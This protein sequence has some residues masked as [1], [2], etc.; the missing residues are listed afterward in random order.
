VSDGGER[1]GARRPRAGRIPAIAALLAGSVLLSRVLGQV[2]EMVLA[3]YLGT[4][5]E[6][7]AYRAAFQIPDILNHFL[8]GGA[9]SV[10]FVPFYTHVRETRGEAAALRLL[11]TVLGTLTAI[12]VVATAALWLG[13]E[14]LVGWLFR[15]F[16]DEPR[17]LTLRLTRILLPAQIFFVAGGVLRAALM[18]NDRFATQALAPLVYNAG[19]IAGG[20]LFGATLGAEG[21]AWGALAGAVVGPF[22]LPLLDIRRAGLG[23]GFRIAPWE[24]DFL[25]YLWRAA[26]LILGLSLLTVD[27]WYDKYFGQF[28]GEGVVAQL[29]YARIVMLAPVAVVGQAV[30]TAA[31]PAFSQL[32][33]EG[34]LPELDR[35]VLA[36][37]RAS[38]G[39]AVLMGAA[40]WALAEPVT[41]LL[42]ERGA[43][44]PED[45][46]RVSALLAVFA[47]AVPA[48]VTQQ[49]AGRAFFAREDM[50]RPMLLGTAVA[51]LAIPLYRALGARFGGEGL[52][53]AGVLAMSANA[54]LLL[55]M[56]RLVH[57][58]PP[59]LPL[60]ATFAR[61]LVVG[62][63]A[64]A[65]AAWAAGLAGPAPAAFALGVAAFGVV[66][67]PGIWWLGDESVREVLTR[68]LSRLRRRRG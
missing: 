8:A 50:W 25:A 59:L 27:E 43:F 5:P 38:L 9:F 55:V 34:R 18:A 26:P 30:A 17:E 19:I 52:A 56:L 45:T 60:I 22:L 12:A 41:A 63:A 57:G 61:T 4:S 28:V 35:A 36:T 20:V 53:G 23:M 11:G 7:D 39:L 48:W 24:R 33:S 64:A 21:F 58:G 49:V 29:G 6:A 62:V 2:R 14:P 44:T 65:L 66:T 16:A 10:A 13:A 15:G 47:F 31:L 51:V 1:S 67:I 32:R 40:A 46:L 54:A 3:G 37:L 68:A 42:Y